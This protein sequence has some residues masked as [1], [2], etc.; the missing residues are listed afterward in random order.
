MTYLSSVDRREALTI[1]N[2]AKP[3]RRYMEALS[4]N[5]QK[6]AEVVET[7]KRA[8]ATRLSCSTE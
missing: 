8:I 7:G 2:D 1:L 4:D 5:L 3:D 6:W